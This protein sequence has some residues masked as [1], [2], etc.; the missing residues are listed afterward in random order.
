[1]NEQIEVA[2]FN[3]LLDTIGHQVEVVRNLTPSNN[4]P[5]MSIGDC[6]EDQ[7]VIFIW[8]KEQDHAEVKKLMAEVNRAIASND[9]VNI[10]SMSIDLQSAGVVRQFNE[11]DTFYRGRLS[12][13]IKH[14]NGDAHV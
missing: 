9:K 8:S 10:S 5:F 14:H 12:Y 7:L 13:C 3:C 1:M 11:G 6:L 2:I 4:Y